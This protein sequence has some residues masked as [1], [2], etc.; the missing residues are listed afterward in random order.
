MNQKGILFILSVI[1]IISSC[2]PEDFT[3]YPPF[4]SIPFSPDY[5]YAQTY[6]DCGPYSVMAVINTLSD[7]KVSPDEIKKQMTWRLKNNYTLP[8]GLETLLKKYHIPIKTELIGGKEQQE[9]V[10]FLR[11]H[12]SRG[13]PVILLGKIKGTNILHYMTALGYKND[14]FYFYD[15][16]QKPSGKTGKTI[17]DNGAE[18]GNHTFSKADVLEFWDRGGYG[19][20]YKNYCIVVLGVKK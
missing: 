15:S 14:L 9:K 4:F 10:D 12:L 17:D 16:Y 6:N 13:R 19:G 8:F 1:L 20:A 5:H 11:W 3:T 7:K 18:T 2:H